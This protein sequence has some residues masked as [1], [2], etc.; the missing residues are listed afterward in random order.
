MLTDSGLTSATPSSRSRSLSWNSPAGI[1]GEQQW[2]AIARQ[3][4]FDSSLLAKEGIVG[5]KRSS[6]PFRRGR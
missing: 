6:S 1:R 4:P 2:P 5:L 3:A